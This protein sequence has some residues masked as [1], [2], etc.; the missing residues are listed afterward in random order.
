MK[1]LQRIKDNQNK[2]N[3]KY[4]EKNKEKITEK[5]KQTYIELKQQSKFS[6]I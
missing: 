2:T 4:Y 5:K 1:R 6:E 3:K